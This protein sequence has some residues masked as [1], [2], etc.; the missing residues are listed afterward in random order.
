MVK[1]KIWLVLSKRKIG[2]QARKKWM[3]IEHA[4]VE[5]DGEHVQQAEDEHAE[6]L[7]VG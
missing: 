5:P 7:F 3:Q 2:S 4:Q 6:V 1:S